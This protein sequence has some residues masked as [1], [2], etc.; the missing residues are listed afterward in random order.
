MRLRERDGE[1][2]DFKEQVSLQEL[3]IS[4]WQEQR[5][6]AEAY[7]FSLESQLTL[8]GE[9]QRQ[10]E[11]QKQENLLLKETIDRMR[12]DMDE[13]RTKADS[14]FGGANNAAMSQAS[15][16]K[17]LGA[18]LARALNEDTDIDTADEDTAVDESEA[19][20]ANDTESEDVIQTIITHKKRVSRTCIFCSLNAYR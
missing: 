12:F 1:I 16:G 18:E 2:K 5:D 13:L 14:Q 3:E 20:D 7:T 10:L 9:S 15:I 19:G 4:K 11:E 6:R 8:A 17:N